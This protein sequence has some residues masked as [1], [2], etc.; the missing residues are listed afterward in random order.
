MRLDADKYSCDL[1]VV[2]PA[3]S[4]LVPDVELFGKV[5]CYRVAVS[6]DLSEQ[7]AILENGTSTQTET[8]GW[9][10]VC[11]F[12]RQASGAEGHSR[13][14]FHAGFLLHAP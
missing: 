7:L 8:K 11:D 2:E 10:N 14:R 4:G 3:D 6:A 1:G 13:R 9:M 12:K 5:F